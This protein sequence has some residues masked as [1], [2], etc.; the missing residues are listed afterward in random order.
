MDETK[1]QKLRL[2]SALAQR[3]R[4]ADAAD[5]DSG[6]VLSEINSALADAADSVGSGFIHFTTREDAKFYY[7]SWK[8]LRHS[9]AFWRLPVSPRERLAGKRCAIHRCYR[10]ARRPR[11]L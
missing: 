6:G 1:M 9:C 3:R 4:G 2:H 5:Q 7:V 11:R 8:R 10:A